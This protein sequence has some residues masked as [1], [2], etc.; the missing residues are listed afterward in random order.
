MRS[1]WAMI[2]IIASLV[3]AASA[4]TNTMTQSNHVDSYGSSDGSI[5]STQSNFGVVM[6]NDN[7]LS[8][9]NGVDLDAT[10]IF[11][12][13]DVDQ[14]N[15]AV[16]VG[17]KNIVTQTN[18]VLDADVSGFANSIEQTQTNL[19]TVV[20]DKNAVWQSNA[21]DA[22]NFGSFS[23]IDQDQSNFGVVIGDKNWLTQTNYADAFNTGYANT[24]DQDETNMAMIFGNKNVGIQSN[25]QIAKPDMANDWSWWNPWAGQDSITQTASN[26]L[27]MIGGY[28]GW[29]RFPGSNSFAVQSNFE[30]AGQD[31]NSNVPITQNVHNGGILVI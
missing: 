3:T 16:I 23:T 31:F 6:G 22:D 20:G 10:G 18:N 12:T 11:S 30:F 8:Q 26:N 28:D 1:I 24:V 29:M 17:N 21:V 9:T 19:L 13:I 5:S 27:I 15:G 14:I 2:L 7:I 25:V 4:Y